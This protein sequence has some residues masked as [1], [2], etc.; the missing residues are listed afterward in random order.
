MQHVQQVQRLL[1]VSFVQEVTIVLLEVQLIQLV[2]VVPFVL[3]EVVWQQTVLQEHVQVITQYVLLV[4]IVQL[5]QI[6]KYV[7]QD[8]IVQME[9]L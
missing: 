1:Q 5:Q 4:I 9:H 8:H 6:T 7:L 2:T 3:L